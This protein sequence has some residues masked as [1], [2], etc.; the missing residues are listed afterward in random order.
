MAHVL[1]RQY[2]CSGVVSVLQRTSTEK[3][4]SVSLVEQCDWAP[5]YPWICGWN[6]VVIKRMC[7]RWDTRLTSR[8]R[9]VHY[10]SSLVQDPT[11][12]RSGTLR[13]ISCHRPGPR[14]Y[15][16]LFLYL[17]IFT[18]SKI[19]WRAESAKQRKCARTFPMRVWDRLI[20]RYPLRPMT[21]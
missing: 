3:D 9:L 18:W 21:A 6:V 13:A 1:L 14:R 12:L 8:K 19:T 17:A 5:V 10:Y 15:S 16:I 4:I 11:P 2:V 7:K 20:S